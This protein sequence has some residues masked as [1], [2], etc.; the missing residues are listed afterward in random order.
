MA[1]VRQGE[2][3]LNLDLTVPDTAR[4]MDFWLGG[5][6]HFEVDRAMARNIEKL[7]PLAASWVRAQRQFL[8]RVSAY[9]HREFHHSCFLV[10][11]SGLPTCGNVHEVIPD[12]HV[13]YTDYNPVTVAY[14]RYILGDN[15]RVRYLNHDARQIHRIDPAE[16]ESLFG[17]SR[18]MA[19]SFVG[20]SYFY[21]D[22][23]LKPVLSQLYEWVAPGSHLAMT[24]IG[25]DAPRYAA[26]SLDAY[27]RMGIPIYPRTRDQ[28]LELL[29][30]WVPTSHGVRAATHWGI[31]DV[32]EPFPPVF[33]YSC[34][35]SRPG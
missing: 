3:G 11:G 6:H 7:T 22:E 18:R 21:P 19:I 26:P 25:E 9:L 28:L 4:M 33:V 16:I 10:A 8:R 12:A 17:P 15:P 20:F 34:L 32:T 23:V 35:V 29:S 24:A 5:S 1:N 2:T 31:D 30:P 14:G 13:L 27:A